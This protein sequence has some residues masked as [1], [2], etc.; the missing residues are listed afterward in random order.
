MFVP[1]VFMIYT[2]QSNNQPASHPLE[3]CCLSF[4]NARLKIESDLNL[5]LI[6][7]CHGHKCQLAKGSLRWQDDFSEQPL[8][9][10]VICVYV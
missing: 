9:L 4:E 6:S 3:L 1:F 10:F 7:E 8:N 2:K 5:E